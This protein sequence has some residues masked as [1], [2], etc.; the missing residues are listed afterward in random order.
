MVRIQIQLEE[1]Q[2][3]RFDRLLESRDCR[4]RS[5]FDRASIPF[6]GPREC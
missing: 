5:W 3:K 1:E 6:S 4:C 2:A